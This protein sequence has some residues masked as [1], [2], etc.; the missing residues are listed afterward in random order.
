MNI[1]DTTTGNSDAATAVAQ[2]LALATKNEAG[3]PLGSA[4]ERAF[5]DTAQAMRLSLSDVQSSSAAGAAVQI[6]RAFE[7]FRAG[8]IDGTYI[9]EEDRDADAQAIDRLLQ[10]ALA[11]LRCDLDAEALAVLDGAFGDLNFATVTQ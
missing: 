3:S 2:A 8:W 11:G 1:F 9:R 5:A 7:L 10:S 4:Q 6:A